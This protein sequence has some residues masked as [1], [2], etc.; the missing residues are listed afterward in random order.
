[1]SVEIHTQTNAPDLPGKKFF[2]SGEKAFFRIVDIAT[3]AANPY[4]YG[5]GFNAYDTLGPPAFFK[6]NT[7]PDL[8]MHTIVSKCYQLDS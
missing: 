1:M 6:C 8:S 3:S 4:E 2:S 7:K 5:N